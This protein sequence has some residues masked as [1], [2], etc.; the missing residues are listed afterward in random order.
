MYARVQIKSRAIK[1]ENILTREFFASV[2]SFTQLQVPENSSFAPEEKCHI[3]SLW[4]L[5]KWF[6]NGA[7]GVKA[8]EGC[9]LEEKKLNWLRTLGSISNFATGSQKFPF[10]KKILKSIIGRFHF[11]HCHLKNQ[12]KKLDQEQ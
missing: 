4:R 2:K 11:R 5:Y 12:I 8:Y 3:C 6:Y 9:Y 1:M 7:S 10:S